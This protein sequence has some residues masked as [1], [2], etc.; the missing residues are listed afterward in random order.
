MK[1]TSQRR[2]R[3]A[4]TVT[5]SGCLAGVGMLG[6]APPDSISNEGRTGGGPIAYAGN[7]CP[8]PPC[9]IDFEPPACPNEKKNKGQ[10]CG[11][12]FAGGSGC[13]VDFLPFCYS[14][15]KFSYRI[16]PA[17]SLSIS[18]S[19]DLVS[20]EVFFANVTGSSGEMHFFNADNIE[21][22]KPLVTNGEC[23]EFMPKI[24]SRVFDEPVRF[25]EVSATGGQVYIDDFSI[26]PGFEPPLGDLNEDC[27]VG[28]KDL[29]ILLGVWGPC[30]PK[31][32][33]P[34]DLDKSGDVGVKDLLILL[35]NWG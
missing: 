26:N 24:Q 23:D 5:L 9:T 3:A 8:L 27:V 33:C 22:G 6:A 11:A 12:I 34:A 28:V 17:S 29:L 19:G 2:V 25:I 18:L 32:D 35:G 14:S 20:L 7:G 16:D 13:V 1:R 21:I 15:G 4:R 30:P 10:I 31:G